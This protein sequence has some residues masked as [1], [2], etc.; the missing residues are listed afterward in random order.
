MKDRATILHR[1][2]HAELH[3]SILGRTGLAVTGAGFGGYRVSSGIATHAEALR[4]TLLSGINLIDTS[5]NYAD[6]GSE[7]LIGEVLADLF[8]KDSIRR[9]EI[10][11][12]SKGGYMQGANLERAI[13]RIESGSGFPDVVQYGDG[14]W[15]CIAPEFLDDQISRSLD[16]L[17]LETIDVYL[18]HNPEY[19][20]QWAQRQ[21]IPVDEARAEYHRR[22]ERAFA[23]LEEEVARG[24]IA[25]Y[26]ISSN[27]FVRPASA[28]DR[29][30]LEECLRIAEG[31]SPNHHFAVI[32]FPGNLLEPGFAREKHSS[33]GKTLIELAREKGLG[34]LVNRPLNAIVDDELIRLADFPHADDPAAERDIERAIAR[35]EEMEEEFR[36]DHVSAMS[37][38][39]EEI[40][41]LREFVAV[42]R[43][44]REHWREFGTIEIFNHALS[45]TFSPRLGYVAKAIRLR[46]ITTEQEWF[47]TYAERAR[48]T[49]RLVASR[50]AA[51]AQERTNDLR[52]R[53]AASLG[54]RPEGS[55]SS[56]AIRSLLGAP[57]VSSVLVGMRRIEYVN[58]VIAALTAGKI[59]SEN[60]WGEGSREDAKSRSRKTTS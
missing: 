51:I 19:Y 38:D 47:D 14:L 44:L 22:I 10:V 50:Y 45:G 32:Q 8:A 54:A 46:G 16:R 59:G 37:D 24:R 58:D 60:W 13:E 11:L 5:A 25:W 9:D 26:G 39:E 42:G 52:E 56:I 28:Y 6:G 1:L 20:L 35:L 4:H 18:L 33:D 30:S 15:H 41:A 48:D 55:F 57:G 53:L 12:V 36:R 2:R 27:T 7:E 3:G 31:I 49:L 17:D 21:N 43:I 34:T 40:A 29:T 23:F